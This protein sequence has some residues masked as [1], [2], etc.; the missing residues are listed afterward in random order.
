MRFLTA[1]L[2]AVVA[3]PAFAATGSFVSLANTNF[4][5]LLSF[6]LFVGVL[7]YYSVPGKIMGLL[8]GRADTIRAELNEAKALREEAQS[9]LA[10]YERKH[11]EVQ[12]Q[13]D[14]I[15]A[16]AKEEATKAAQAA[17]GDIAT[18]IERRLIAAQEQIESAQA[19]AVKDVR[20]RAISVAVAAAKDIV[21]KQLDAKGSNT[22]IDEAIA[23]VGAKM[24]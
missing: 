4:V 20:D 15:V 3:S 18:S 10:S 1:A 5:V 9:L 8:D 22:L 7:F 19:A 6:L 21:A 11:K 17:K 14:R 2:L 12:A 13:A 24:H 23:T 16:H